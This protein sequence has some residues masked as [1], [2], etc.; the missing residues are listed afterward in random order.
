MRCMFL[1]FCFL[2]S[3]LF[4]AQGNSLSGD[5]RSCEADSLDPFSVEHVQRF[6]GEEW[7]VIDV[8]QTIEDDQP[9]LGGHLFQNEIAGSFMCICFS[10]L[11]IKGLFFTL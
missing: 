7:Q 1:V 8:H 9:R 3:M 2:G 6:L 11:K 10:L 4:H 5:F